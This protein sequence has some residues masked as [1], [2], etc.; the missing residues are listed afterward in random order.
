MLPRGLSAAV[1]AEVVAISA[2]P[3]ASMYPYIIIIVIITTVILSALSIPVFGGKKN[4]EQKNSQPAA[5]D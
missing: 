4:L 2:I 1:V 3:N 5:D